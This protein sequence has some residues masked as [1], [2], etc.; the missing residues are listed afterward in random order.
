MLGSLLGIGSGIFDFLGASGAADDAQSVAQ[1]NMNWQMDRYWDLY[2]LLTAPQRDPYGNELIYRPGGIGW[3]YKLTP[4]TQGL[5]SAQQAEQV[6]SLTE[7]ARMNRDFRRRQEDVSK[8]AGGEYQ[9]VL[10]DYKY[11]EK[12]DEASIIDDLTRL[13][14]INRTKGLE[15]G[16]EIL[17]KQA[18]RQESNPSLLRDIS[19]NLDETWGKSLEESIIQG[20]Q[21]GQKEFQDRSAF[22]DKDLQ[23]WLGTFHNIDRNQPQAQLAN[24]TIGNELENLRT[25]AQSGAQSGM[26]SGAGLINSAAGMLANKAGV[27]PPSTGGIAKSIGSLFGGGGGSSGSSGI[28][29]LFGGAA[30]DSV[31]ATAP[32]A[33]RGIGDAVTPSRQTSGIV[34][35]DRDPIWDDPNNP[36]YWGGEYLP[37][38][39]WGR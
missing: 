1:Q 10:A 5:L 3:D 31:G 25:S 18:L 37:T 28:G 14:T 22:R 32:A 29:S 2:N 19:R 8:Q 15:Q 38:W 30:G 39:S 11:G 21:A 27:A 13:M 17:A 23:S 34:T 26:I 16:G 6:K 12:P 9:N 7:D 20:R 35:P 24:P 33:A 4:E 36:A